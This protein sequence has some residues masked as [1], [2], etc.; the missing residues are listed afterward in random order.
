LELAEEAQ[1]LPAPRLPTF[2][3]SG[4]VGREETAA[5]VRA[6]LA[7][8]HG[9]HPE[10]AKDGMLANPQRLGHG[11]ARPPL[12]VEGPD[13]LR[14]RPPP[15][16][17]WVGQ[18]LGR[19]RQGW[20]WHRHG[21][22]A[23]G[24][25]HRYLAE[26]LMDGLEG[27]AVGVQHLVEGFGEGL[28]QVNA[29]GDLDRVGGALTGPVGVRS[30]PI[31]GD[32]ADA[33]MGRSPEGEGLGLT[34]GP[35]GERSP[36]FEIAPHGALGLAFPRG[37]II[38]AEH[39][40]CGKG[41]K[42]QTTQQAQ[43]GV[44]TDGEA[45]VTAQSYPCCPRPRHGDVHQPVPA[46]RRPPRPGGDERPP[47]RGE[48][49]ARAA[50]IGAEERPHLQVEHDAP[51]SPGEICHRAAIATMDTPRRQPA[52]RT[53]DQGRRRRHPPRQLGGGVVHVPGVEVEPGCIGKPAGQTCH[54]EPAPPLSDTK[55]SYCH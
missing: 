4:G 1:G 33:G 15:R 25:R 6:A 40:G 2:E 35:E 41:R 44:T 38:N 24:P 19:A 5:A 28:P 13:L 48:N 36:P 51:W 46:P 55:P 20:G 54:G 16:L 21:H 7:L 32:H 30:G 50:T 43:E 27:V 34:I 22:R 29:I 3:E 42:R 52:D 45:Q 39:L 31:P 18:V 37:P 49:P 17:A 26:G 47:P 12:L 14:E 23:V 53:V 10:G 11:P 9:L 8:G